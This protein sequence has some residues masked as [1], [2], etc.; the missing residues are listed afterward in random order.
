MPSINHRPG[1]KSLG[2][3]IHCLHPHHLSHHWW[4]PSVSISPSSIAS[5]ILLRTYTKAGSAPCGANVVSVNHHNKLLG[6]SFSSS[7]FSQRDWVLK[8]KGNTPKVTTLGGQDK[9]TQYSSSGS[10]W[11]TTYEHSTGSPWLK[12]SDWRSACVLESV[13]GIKPCGSERGGSKSRKTGS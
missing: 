6:R 9:L 5:R 3:L 2:F 8:N 10:V 4:H 7:F 12:E 1:H 11:N 13:L